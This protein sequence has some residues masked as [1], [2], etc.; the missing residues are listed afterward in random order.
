MGQSDEQHEQFVPP[1]GS[2]QSFCVLTTLSASGQDEV[3]ELVD[4]LE[5]L[6]EDNMRWIARMRELGVEPPCCSKCGGV[7]YRLPS[8]EDYAAGAILFKCAPDMFADGVAAC[9]TIAAYNVAAIRVIEG[10]DAWVVIE[11]GDG[12]ASSYHAVVGT[13]EGIVDPTETMERG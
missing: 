12:G 4:I 11:D 8:E 10:G 7:L 3:D 5:I 2:P 9:G 13:P 6:V 1:P